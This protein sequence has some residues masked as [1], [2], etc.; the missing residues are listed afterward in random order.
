HAINTTTDIY[1]DDFSYNQ[2]NDCDHPINYS[3]LTYAGSTN[4]TWSGLPNVDYVIYE[5]GTTGFTPGT[6]TIDTTSS[7]TI[8]L[9]GLIPNTIYDVYVKS[10]CNS[11]DTSVAGP[12]VTF[13]TLSG[14]LFAYFGKALKFNGA[15]T[16]SSNNYAFPT[17]ND[18]RTIEAWIKREGIS[19]EDEHIVSYSSSSAGE[20]FGIG[21][22][23]NTGKVILVGDANQFSGNKV[24]TDGFWHHVA[25]THNG[26]TTSIYVDG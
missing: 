17:G 24:I 4:I 11:G 13:Q 1:I 21:I 20:R 3:V 19:I 5:Y 18:S 15:G 8:N 16:I 10:V 23:A 2:V 9:I 7:T 6:G 25:I 22:E 12:K 14:E 26:T